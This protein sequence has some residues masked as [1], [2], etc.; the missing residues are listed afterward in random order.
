IMNTFAYILKQ[1]YS[2]IQKRSVHSD[3]IKEILNT[4]MELI[5]WPHSVN[6]T[7][8]LIHLWITG[9]NGNS[10]YYSFGGCHR[11]AACQRVQIKT[12]P[13]KIIKSNILELHAYL[14]TST[15]NL[16]RLKVN[17]G[18]VDSFTIYG[19]LLS[20]ASCFYF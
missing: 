10:Y 7:D 11:L 1:F 5:S 18:V 19:G 6:P 14:G 12:I 17:C 4:P 15:P 16:Q 13:A 2:N 9:G 8:L 3:N 20:T